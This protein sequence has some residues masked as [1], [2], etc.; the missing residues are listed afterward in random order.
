MHNSSFDG[1]TFSGSIRQ[2]TFWKEF[3]DVVLEFDEVWLF[4]FSPK[5]VSCSLRNP[6]RKLFPCMVEEFSDWRV[7]C[8]IVNHSAAQSY[9]S[10]Y[11]IISGSLVQH[12]GKEGYWKRFLLC[13]FDIYKIWITWLNIYGKGSNFNSCFTTFVGIE[14][15]WKRVMFLLLSCC[16]I[17]ELLYTFF[18]SGSCC[19]LTNE[20]CLIFS[21][22]ISFSIWGLSQFLRF[23]LVCSQF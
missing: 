22:A 6:M 23:G 21:N 18:W 7:D 20:T 12:L 14:C 2:K 9:W 13:D 15:L 10:V 16:C 3:P 1:T 8:S 17:G 11:L 5:A 4:R 19:T